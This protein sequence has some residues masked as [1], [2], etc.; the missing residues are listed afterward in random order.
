MWLPSGLNAALTKKEATARRWEG[1]RAGERA[2]AAG[3][4]QARPS[5]HCCYS[6]GTKGR[7]ASLPACSVRM[8]IQWGYA[9]EAAARPRLPARSCPCLSHPCARQR[10]WWGRCPGGAAGRSCAARPSGSPAA[11]RLRG[12]QRPEQ[13]LQDLACFML[14]TTLGHKNSPQA[15]ASQAQAPPARPT[16]P[17]SSG[18]ARFRFLADKQRGPRAELPPHPALPRQPA[19]PPLGWRASEVMPCCFSPTL[20]SG[21]E[22]S[23]CRSARGAERARGEA[24]WRR[25]HSF[26]MPSTPAG[27][28]GNPAESLA[29]PSLA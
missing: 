12:R 22:Q 29:Q 16:G 4:A 9:R 11:P 19:R 3:V 18:R 28:A 2:W 8:P 15:A 10:A 21:T 17:R 7:Q 25:S 6:L 20:G 27:C 1:G 24:V 23:P 13:R 26:R 5:R 14:S